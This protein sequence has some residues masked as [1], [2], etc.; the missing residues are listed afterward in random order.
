VGVV[1]A[2]LEIEEGRG[3]FVDFHVETVAEGEVSE[4]GRKID[5]VIK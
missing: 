3:E 2:E 1:E 5:P 4:R